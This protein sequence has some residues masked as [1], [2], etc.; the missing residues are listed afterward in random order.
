MDSLP[1]CSRRCSAVVP[2]IPPRAARHNSRS[3]AI[4]PDNSR[5]KPIWLKPLHRSEN[6]AGTWRYRG[7]LLWR[8]NLVAVGQRCGAL[9]RDE[10]VVERMVAG[11]AAGAEPVEGRSECGAVFAVDGLL[12]VGKWAADL[13]VDDI[14]AKQVGDVIETLLQFTDLIIGQRPVGG[15]AGEP[16]LDMAHLLQRHNFSKSGLIRS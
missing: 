8:E 12:Q 4:L 1:T 11:V 2:R 16:E 10:R 7:L 6:N 14:A 13:L 9:Y 15:M 5:T 3:M